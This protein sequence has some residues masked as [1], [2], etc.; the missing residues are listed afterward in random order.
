[1][2]IDQRDIDLGKL[3]RETVAVLRAHRLGHRQQNEQ[4][5][6]AGKATAL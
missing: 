6:H 4:I 2:V 1:M 3:R 5:G